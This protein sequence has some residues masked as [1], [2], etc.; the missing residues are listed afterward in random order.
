MVI[1]DHCLGNVPSTHPPTHP[2]IHSS[3]YPPT[4]PTTYP[5]ISILPSSLF[6][7]IRAPSLHQSSHVH[8]FPCLPLHDAGLFFMDSPSRGSRREPSQSNHATIYPIHP[9]LKDSDFIGIFYCFSSFGTILFIIIKRFRFYRNLL[10]FFEFRYYPYYY[11]YSFFPDGAIGI[12]NLQNR[13]TF[14][15]QT[16]LIYGPLSDNVQRAFWC[17]S[18]LPFWI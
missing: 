15:H 12:A 1:N 13:I 14:S 4:H 7:A 8:W 16:Q 2:S 3:I 11:Y 9:S 5:Y 6:A 17:C 10:L 18:G